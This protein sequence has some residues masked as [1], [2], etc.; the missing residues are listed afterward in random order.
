[1]EALPLVMD[2]SSGLWHRPS[3]SDMKIIREVA[4]AY[5]ELPFED[6]DVFLDLGAHIGAASKLALVRGAAKVIAVEPDPSNIAILRRNLDGYPARIIEAVVGDKAGSA[7]LYAHAAKPHLSSTL[8]NEV[9]RNAIEVPVVALGA[10]LTRYRPTVVKCDIEFDEYGLTRI[11]KLS[12]TVRV[13]AI[14]IHVRYDLVFDTVRQSGAELTARRVAALE[15]VAAVE[16]QGFK[17]VAYHV[18]EYPAQRAN[19]NSGLPPDTASIEGIW[20]RG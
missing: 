20:E 6:G 11:E 10:L 13:L 16:A 4:S 5:R 14:E 1:M 9:G 17:R 3:S 19:D 12:P 18:K 2:E 7:T 15:M 8:S